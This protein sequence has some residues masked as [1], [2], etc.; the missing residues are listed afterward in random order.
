ML[1]FHIKVPTKRATMIAVARLLV[2]VASRLQKVRNR[3]SWSLGPLHQQRGFV[4]AIK[5]GTLSLPATPMWFDFCP[6][7]LALSLSFFGWVCWQSVRPPG[8]ALAVRAPRWRSG[9]MTDLRAA[10]LCLASDASDCLTGHNLVI[11]GG[12]SL[13]VE[14]ADEEMRRF[15][16]L[17]LLLGLLSDAADKDTLLINVNV[18]KTTLSTHRI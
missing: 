2:T 10:L 15:F 7:L 8:A 12:Q 1:E 4:F 13:R 5:V 11:D 9:S 17:L 6:P 18:N 16:S 3:I 14:G